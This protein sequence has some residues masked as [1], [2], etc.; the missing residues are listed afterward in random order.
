MSLLTNNLPASH[1]AS[2]LVLRTLNSD[3]LNH[4]LMGLQLLGHCN[5]LRH[6]EIND[7]FLESVAP[8]TLQSGSWSGHSASVFMAGAGAV[9]LSDHPSP[10]RAA[11][12]ELKQPTLVSLPR[13][14]LKHPGQRQLHLSETALHCL[15]SSIFT[16]IKP[17][18]VPVQNSNRQW[19]ITPS[20]TFCL[21]HQSVIQWYLI[22]LRARMM[23]YYAWLA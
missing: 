23:I 15:P 6:M 5:I 9:T 4:G 7:D 18:Y 22:W 12:R 3:L 14:D 19:Q 20:C 8:L 1:S 2:D 13:F 17:K 11:T 21:S 16:C 10:S